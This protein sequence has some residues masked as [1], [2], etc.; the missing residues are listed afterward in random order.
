MA[1]QS[2]RAAKKQKV[3]ASLR[4]GSTFMQAAE[5]A[6]VSTSTAYR[7]CGDD[8]A[9]NSQVKALLAKRSQPSSPDT[10][11]AVLEAM[12]NPVP[13]D[14]I[15]TSEELRSRALNWA[16]NVSAPS[17]LYADAPT[18]ISEAYESVADVLDGNAEEPQDAMNL[19]VGWRDFA[20]VREQVAQ[21]KM[22]EESADSAIMEE[23]AF[24]RRLA[25]ASKEI[26]QQWLV[27]ATEQ[28]NRVSRAIASNPPMSP[29]LLKSLKR[30]K[31]R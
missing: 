17:D 18:H 2:Q 15:L 28:S 10:P 29:S 21:E 25:Y 12:L 3:L 20:E 27:V 14:E 8:P 5:S 6:G 16:G 23:A 7:W 4:N 22:N 19:V 13:A 26:A 11:R 1:T 24:N 30:D 9:F 31:D